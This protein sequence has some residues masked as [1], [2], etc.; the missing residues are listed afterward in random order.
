M[1]K[2]LSQADLHE[3]LISALGAPN[4]V[5]HGDI[6][7]KP[8][9]LDL[10][11]P[12]P[13]KVRAY[14]FNA[15]KPPGGRPIGEHKV[16]LIAPG[17]QRGERGNFD[18]SGGRIVLLIGYVLE[19]DV[20]VF[21]DA[22]LYTDFAWSRNVQVK[23]QTVVDATAGKVATQDRVLR[24]TKGTSVTETVIATT[25]QNILLGITARMAATYQRMST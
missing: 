13:H 19:D 25:G 23:S 2:R 9:V 8:I 21:W 1:Q 10:A 5:S 20:F 16:Q 7:E 18:H 24:P 14:M 11:S 4:V 12:L 17:Q 15:T 3:S 6:T 22:G